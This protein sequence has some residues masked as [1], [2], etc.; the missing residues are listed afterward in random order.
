MT[1]ERDRDE[2]LDAIVAEYFEVKATAIIAR[3]VRLL[4]HDEVHDDDAVEQL[5]DELMDALERRYG[6]MD[7][8]WRDATEQLVRVELDRQ[9]Q[10]RRRADAA[11]EA[12]LEG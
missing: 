7:E 4:D 5:G 9:I 11:L 3:A 10:S 6:R 2:R 12:E 8:G 1:E